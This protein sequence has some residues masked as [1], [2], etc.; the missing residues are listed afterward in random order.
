MPEER[1]VMANTAAGVTEYDF[2]LMAGVI[3]DNLAK[4]GQPVDMANK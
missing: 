1:R 4:E 3:R 2:E